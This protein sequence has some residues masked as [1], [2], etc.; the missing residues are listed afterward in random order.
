[1][2]IEGFLVLAVVGA[3][4]GGVVVVLRKLKGRGGED[5]PY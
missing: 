4:A 5:T 2:P 3:V 1:M